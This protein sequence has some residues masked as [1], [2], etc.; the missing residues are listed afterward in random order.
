MQTDADIESGARRAVTLPTHLDDGRVP[1][2]PGCYW[3]RTQVTLPPELR[4]RAVQLVVPELAAVARLRVDGDEAI[5]RSTSDSSGYRRRGPHSWA[6]PAGPTRDGVLELEIQVEH[7]WT[8]SAWWGTAPRLLPLAATDPAARAVDIFNLLISG[9]ALV[10]LLQIGL[11]SLMVFVLDRRRR[12]Y[13]WFAVQALCAGVYPLYLSA[14][15]QRLFG[16]YDAPVLGIMLEVAITAS[17]A[18]THGFFG[19]ARPWRGFWPVCALFAAVSLVLHQPF[20]HTRTA[21]VAAASYVGALLLYQIV[22]CSRLVWR[23]AGAERRN[24]FYCLLSWLCL[25]VTTTP[26]FAYWLGF[27]D[28][29]GGVRLGGLGLALF[30]LFLSLLLSQHHINSLARAD[31][32]NA[33]L[34]RRVD[35]LERRRTEIE[36]LNLEMR[37]Q[38]ADRAAQIYAALALAG[39]GSSSDAPELEV[40]EVVQRRYRIE[41]RL[42]AGGMGTVYEVTRLADERRLALKLAR[43][44]H[45]E[46]LARLARE[47]HMASTIHHAN[48]VGILDV[49][50]ASSGF[51]FLV[52]ELF[53]GESLHEQR[54]SFGDPTWAVPLLRQLADGLAALH[55]AGIVHRDL[56]PGNVLV[57]RGAAGATVV[58]ISD[59]GIALHPDFEAEAVPL[60]RPEAVAAAAAASGVAASPQPIVPDASIWL[61]GGNDQITDLIA[62]PARATPVPVSVPA[63]LVAAAVTAPVKTVRPAAEQATDLIDQQAR[64]SAPAMPMP[65]PRTP[66]SRTPSSPVVMGGSSFLTRTGYL[67][68]TPTYIAPEL[69]EGRE[70]LTFAAD[71]F[72]FGVIAYEMIRGQRP[73]AEP[74]VLAL[75]ENREVPAPQ[76]ITVAW[77]GS[78]AELA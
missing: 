30:G 44:L 5:D 19:L 16:I 56:K 58:K 13:L 24:A 31:E 76:P 71:M 47:A 34:A 66:T 61:R 70:M 60:A 35:Q 51:L 7:R 8:Q 74:P 23:R 57:T 64:S 4:G 55:K 39:S 22:V 43:E 33:E 20:V 6:I 41:K 54:E 15:S 75:M 73:F 11:T 9:A 42:G 18:F 26:D 48:V 3:L 36:Q 78:P 52:M 40:G 1:D 53:E 77:S 37:R 28:A 46:S 50:V 10:A 25:A 21:A 17:I 69:A 67:P 59:F 32:L 72:A 62:V 63:A 29:L 2:R 27:G 14:W 49:D 38:V 12:P 65:A 68:G 45:G